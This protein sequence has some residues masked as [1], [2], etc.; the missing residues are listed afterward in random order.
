VERRIRVPLAALD[1]EGRA[2]IEAQ[3]TEIAIFLVDGVPHAVENA[4]P[5]EGNPLVLGE[6]A[7][8]TLTCAF[9]QWRFD[10]ETGA[11]LHGDRP[12]TRYPAAIENDEIVIDAAA[13]PG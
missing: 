9:H 4:C 5:H 10:L 11:C 8:G 3:G 12:L 1:R 2:V 7:G 13:S 6:L